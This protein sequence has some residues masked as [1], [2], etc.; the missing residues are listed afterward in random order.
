[1]AHGLKPWII[2]PLPLPHSRPT[3]LTSPPSGPTA[4][5]SRAWFGDCQPGPHSQPVYS[6]RARLLTE[7]RVP[8]L[9][10]SHSRALLVRLTGRW[11]RVVSPHVVTT[12][13]PAI[14]AFTTVRV[15]RN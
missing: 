14:A 2:G 3:P 11:A 1:M 6:A 8:L 9:S 12:S 15:S 7:S 10:L 5:S 13:E 4:I